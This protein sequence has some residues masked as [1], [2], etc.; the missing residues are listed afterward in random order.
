MSMV[1]V[2]FKAQYEL[3]LYVGMPLTWLATVVV[4]FLAGDQFYGGQRA[5]KVLVSLAMLL[6]F[7]GY[8]AFVLAASGKGPILIYASAASFLIAYILAEIGDWKGRRAAKR[9]AD[10]TETRYLA[11]PVEGGMNY[12]PPTYGSVQVTTN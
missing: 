8:L 10:A 7:G 11:K 12:Q 2:I 3:G 5:S 4:L 1:Y 9:A 6:N